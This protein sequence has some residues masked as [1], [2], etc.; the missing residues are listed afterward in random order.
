MK[1]YV[2]GYGSLVNLASAEKA[3]KRPVLSDNVILATLNGYQRDWSYFN[4]IF[5]KNLKRNTN[6]LFL[7]LTSND[8]AYCNGILIKVTKD[9][10]TNLKIREKNYA[11]IDVT[12]SILAVTDANVNLS[13]SIIYSFICIDPMYK[14]TESEHFIM[15]KYINLVT[16]G[17]LSFGESFYEEYVNTTFTPDCNKLDGEYD[18][19]NIEQNNFR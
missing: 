18:F 1:V 12:S 10:L 5:S 19:I 4:T 3:I 9:E 11:C 7:N 8:T 13:D 2:F 14:Y 15:N 17:F 16:A 6:A